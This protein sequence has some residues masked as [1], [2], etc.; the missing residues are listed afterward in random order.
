[1]LRNVVIVCNRLAL[2]DVMWLTC[3]MF[4]PV[5][6]PAFH[7]VYNKIRYVLILT[8]VIPRTIPNFELK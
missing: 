7:C 2:S 4:D 6:L 8:A 1:M 3:C 5:N